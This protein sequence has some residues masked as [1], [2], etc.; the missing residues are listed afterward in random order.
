MAANGR[1]WPQMA[2]NG[3]KWPQMAAFC[4]HNAAPL[5]R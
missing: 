2:A 4:M 5:T 1:K 3:R